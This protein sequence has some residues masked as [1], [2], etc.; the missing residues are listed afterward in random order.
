M[1]VPSSPFH[2]YWPCEWACWWCPTNKPKYIF[3]IQDNG[4]SLYTYVCVRPI[5]LNIFFLNT[6]QWSIIY[7]YNIR[8]TANDIG[9]IFVF[10]FLISFL[11][12]YNFTFEKKNTNTISFCHLAF[13]AVNIDPRG[14]LDNFL[15]H[16]FLQH[17]HGILACISVQN[18]CLILVFNCRKA[19]TALYYSIWQ[20]MSALHNSCWL[21]WWLSLKVCCGTDRSC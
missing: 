8:W 9:E 2:P 4:Q 11:D 10:Y 13:H 3:W 7:T 15:I 16:L 18:C 1:A 6:W 20:S 5:N 21:Q 19:L 14:H 17:L 12:M